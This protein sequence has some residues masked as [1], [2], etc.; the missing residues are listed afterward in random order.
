MTAFSPDPHPG[1]NLNYRPSVNAYG[2]P[3][4]VR[5]LELH[6]VPHV[7]RFPAPPSRLPSCAMSVSRPAPVPWV[8]PRRADD[9]VQAGGDLDA[10]QSPVAW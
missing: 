2:Y 3:T 6:D 9:D 7:C 5:C 1:L 4:G 8:P 10:V